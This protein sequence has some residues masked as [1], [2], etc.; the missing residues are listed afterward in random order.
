MAI[1]VEVEVAQEPSRR[2][3]I[4]AT[5]APAKNL[6]RWHTPPVERYLPGFPK[7][8]D[9]GVPTVRHLLTHR[10]GVPHRVTA[11][12]DETQPLHP[13]DIVERVRSQGLLFEPGT[14]RLYSSAGFTCLARVI[15]VIEKKPFDS[16]LAERVFRPAGMTSALSETGE[17]LMPG[18]ALPHRLGADHRH[19]VV[20]SAPYKDLRFLTGGAVYAR[21][22][23]LLQFV[24]AIR[25]GAFGAEF[26]Q[27]AFGGD[28]K[29]WH[30]WMGRTSGYEAS[31]DV[32]PGEDLTFIFLSNLS[33]AAN[34]Q[35]RE[36]IQNALIGRPAT[37]VLLPPAVREQ[38]EEPESL[39][40]SYGPAEITL[41]DGRLFRGDNE[42]YPVE[43]R[44]YYIP[45]SG[46][47]IRFRR[48]STGAVDALISIGGGGEETVLPK[49]GDR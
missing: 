20:K 14:R 13:A 42:F 49:S 31:V 2:I 12:I 5:N 28:Q 35:L 11:P 36:Q 4:A 38:F 16:V 44:R 32:L 15:E 10:S 19:V 46:S 37:A 48:G 39:M 18:R 1:I 24:Q 27:E 9:G 26:A 33:S 45:A 8:P 7:G 23:D 22:Q 21:A 25:H 43:G 3:S 29:T 17:R 30:R 41:I 6:W 40:G 34:W 47:I